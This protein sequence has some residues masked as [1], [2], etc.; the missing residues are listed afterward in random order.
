MP[1]VVAGAF[2]QPRATDA[3]STDGLIRATVM[4]ETAGVFLKIDFTALLG[5]TSYTWPNPFR[6]TIWRQLPGGEPEPVRGADSVAQYG[7]IMHAYDDEVTFGQQVDYWV[8]APTRSGDPIITSARVS[9]RT[10][11]PD[12]GFNSPGVW[13][14]NLE[15]PD[16]SVPARCLDWSAGSWASRNA[17][18]DVWGSP[19]PAVVTDVRKSYN[20]QMTVLTKDEDEYQAL[21]AALDA[22]VVYVV[23]LERHRRRTGYYLVGDIA[24]TRVGRPS[25][26]YDSWSI[27]LTG[28]GRP[29][30]AGHSL[31]VPGRSYGD[32]RRVY[33]RYV[34]VPYVSNHMAVTALAAG[35]FGAYSDARVVYTTGA[36]ITT[37][38]TVR[39]PLTAPAAL[40][41]TPG[42]SL[43]QSGG[44]WIGASSGSPVIVRPGETVTLS[45]T[46]ANANAGRTRPYVI[47][48]GGSAGETFEIA[49]VTLALDSAP[50]T[51]LMPAGSGVWTDSLSW[52]DEVSNAVARI[53]PGAHRR[54][55]AGT[56][57]Y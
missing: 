51:N 45:H 23:G 25:S 4:P 54:Y 9:V 35:T 42:L 57:P 31:T 8:S 53:V 24:P 14:K 18:A 13:I 19:Y 1:I 37:K 55:G 7:G 39:V 16:L 47:R 41:L 3:L 32:R 49:K 48:D 52:W 46:S 22:S 27:P 44:A 56:E 43:W 34:D 29:A 38:I 5:N 17:T 26:T 21:L 36:S 20:T 2:P 30:S 11:E 15:N 12:G 28:M 33:G 6:A 10:W 40:P 50:G